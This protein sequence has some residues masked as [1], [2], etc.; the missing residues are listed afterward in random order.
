MEVLLFNFRS[1]FLIHVPMNV[2]FPQVC[3]RWIYITSLTWIQ[4]MPSVHFQCFT[5]NHHGCDNCNI[6]RIMGNFHIVQIF[7]YIPCASSVSKKKNCENLSM[8]KKFITCVSLF[9]YVQSQIAKKVLNN[10]SALVLC[11]SL[12]VEWPSQFQWIDNSI[13]SKKFD[14]E[15]KSKRRGG[16]KRRGGASGGGASGE[17]ASRPH[18]KQR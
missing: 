6:N 1:W 14:S 2:A 10:V 8:Q 12:E 16:G 5:Q 11:Q 17:G 7:I 18:S 3:W 9:T 4:E 13:S 15:G